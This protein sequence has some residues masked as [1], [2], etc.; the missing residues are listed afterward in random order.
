M[1]DLDPIVRGLPHQSKTILVQIWA[2]PGTKVPYPIPAGLDT[3]LIQGLVN[4]AE[5]RLSLSQTGKAVLR[6]LETDRHIATW[7]RFHNVMA[8]AAACDGQVQGLEQVFR[9]DFT[10]DERDLIR[11][12]VEQVLAALAAAEK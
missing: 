5:G 7:D 3:L 2:N 4:V 11:P 6:Y 12:V 1:T 9:D 8:T 10:P